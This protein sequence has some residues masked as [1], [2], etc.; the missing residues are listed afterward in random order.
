LICKGY[1]AVTA[2]DQ[3]TYTDNVSSPTDWK[4]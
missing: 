1:D 3:L 4:P 2:F